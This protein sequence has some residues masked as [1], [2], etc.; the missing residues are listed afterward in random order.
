MIDIDLLLAWGATFKKVAKGEI[1]LLEGSA[2][3]F[4]HQLVS[5]EIRSVNINDDGKEFIQAIIEQGECFGELPLFDDELY[6]A[7]TV[8]NIDSVIIRLHKPVFDRMVKEHPEL[9]KAFNRLLAHNMRF[10]ILTLKAIASHHPGNRITALLDQL[11]E[12]QR[13]ICPNCNQLQL[14]RQ[15]IADMT[16]LRV[17]TVIR[18]MRQMHEKGV[19]I[20]NKGKVYC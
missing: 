5:G 4:Y 16:G 11:K 13:N 20:I 12:E 15:Q 9:N 19:L 6:T 8:T 17:E 18:S 3:S 1:V 10:K 7:T 2:C 14:T